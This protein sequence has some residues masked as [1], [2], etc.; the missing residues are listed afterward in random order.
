MSIVVL[1]FS[2]WHTEL[3]KRG[4][5]QRWFVM[6]G[7][8]AMVGSLLVGPLASTTV[9]AAAASATLHTDA[10]ADMP[11]HKPAKPSKPCPNCPQKSCPDMGNCMV[12]CFQFVFSPVSEEETFGSPEPSQFTPAASQVTSG[13]LT[14]PLLR[15]PSV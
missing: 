11:C 9:Q 1:L 13:A 4:Q 12:K 3:M 14:P 6:L 2:A 8:V 5:L 10:S 7:M 15:P